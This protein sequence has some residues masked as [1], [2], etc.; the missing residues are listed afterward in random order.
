MGQPLKSFRDSEIDF[1]V[2]GSD[3]DRSYLESLGPLEKPQRPS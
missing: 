1:T 2:Y 3:F